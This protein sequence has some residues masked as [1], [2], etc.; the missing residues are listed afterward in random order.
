M[1][2]K[3]WEGDLAKQ[4]FTLRGRSAKSGRF[5]SLKQARKRKST[6]VVERIPI[7]RRRKK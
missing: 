1:L 7:R 5:I 2:K 6:S 3:I 4:K